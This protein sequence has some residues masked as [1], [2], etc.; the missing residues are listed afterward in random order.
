MVMG[1]AVCGMHYTGM[2]A[3]SVEMEERGHLNG[4]TSMTLIAPIA[5]AVVFV[6]MG[7]IYSVLAAPTDE[8]RAGAAYIN[9]RL[10]GGP[11]GPN[12]GWAGES[13]PQPAGSGSGRPG[14]GDLWA[15]SREAADREAASRE[16][17]R[18][19]ASREAAARAGAASGVPGLGARLAGAGSFGGP[20]AASA[21][22]VPGVNGV[23]AQGG[24]AGA[25]G[26]NGAGFASGLG[27][28]LMGSEPTSGAPVADAGRWDG[29]T[30]SAH[31]TVP[32][33]VEYQHG[34]EPLP[35]RSTGGQAPNGGQ[36][37]T[38]GQTPTPPWP[39]TSPTLA[40]QFQNRPRTTQD[41]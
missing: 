16:A 36:A 15:A 22:G 33:T 29:L 13:A 38:A 8:D 34:G 6:V 27:A 10:N 41:H 5:L 7:L 12:T 3:M 17:A 1:V 26:G 39:P 14:P 20:A 18:E 32:A 30:D 40:Q 21:N 28:G 19:A 4:A 11:V 37:P 9:A 23:P 25:N 35:Q 31:P 2:S 24:L